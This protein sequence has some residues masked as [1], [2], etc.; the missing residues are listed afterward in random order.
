MFG[1][2]DWFWNVLALTIFVIVNIILWVYQRRCKKK[3]IRP[4][5]PFERLKKYEKRV[6]R[7]MDIVI[8]AVILLG[9]IVCGFL[10]CGIFII[11]RSLGMPSEYVQ[12]DTR[13]YLP[14]IFLILSGHSTWAVIMASLLT[15]FQKNITIKKRIILLVM[16]II[17][18][19]LWVLYFLS[20]SQKDYSRDLKL[21]YGALF[22]LVFINWPAIIL[23]QPFVEFFPRLVSKIPFFPKPADEQVDQE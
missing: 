12:M 19:L 21:L 4:K 10:I 22:S 5:R 7:L 3:G 6:S 17:V 20:C 13:L 8:V 14:V 15:P 23:G 9:A 16:C 2:P 18:V 1:L 11:D